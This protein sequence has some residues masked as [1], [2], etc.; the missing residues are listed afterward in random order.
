MVFGASEDVK[1]TLKP[2]FLIVE[3]PNYTNTIKENA[4]A[5]LQ[6]KVKNPNLDIGK[7]G[8]GSCRNMFEILLINS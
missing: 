4:N 6:A 7:F 1:D 2:G 3:P 8:N 5:V